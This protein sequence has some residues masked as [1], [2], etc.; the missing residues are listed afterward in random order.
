[1]G[2]VYTP[3]L[4]FQLD[5]DSVQEAFLIIINS[6]LRVHTVVRRLTDGEVSKEAEVGCA[7]RTLHCA[8]FCSTRVD[9]IS[10]TAIPRHHE[11]GRSRYRGEKSGVY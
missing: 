8:V 2:L 7:G 4:T 11:N 5:K 3:K 9:P 6:V 10:P 1:M